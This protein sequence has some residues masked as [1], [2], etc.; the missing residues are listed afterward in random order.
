V[1]SALCAVLAGI[2]AALA[3][4]GWVVGR[5]SLARIVPGLAA[6]KCNEAIALLLA[7]ASALAYVRCAPGSWPRRG[8]ALAAGAVVLI[9]AATLAEYAFAT[10]LG[11][12]QLLVHG[13]A[14]PYPGRP[15]ANTALVLVALGG[16]LLCSDHRRAW[17]AG[18]LLAWLAATLALLAL[19]GYTTSAGSLLGSGAHDRLAAS[20]ASLLALLL[21]VDVLLSGLQRSELAAATSE[22]PRAFA[23]RRLLPAAVGVPLMLA[24]LAQAAQRIGLMSAGIQAWVL[25]SAVSVAAVVVA[26][27]VASASERIERERSEAEQTAGILAALVKSSPSAI[28]ALTRS[29]TIVDWNSSAEQLYG[30]TAVQAVGRSITILNP[31]E[32]DVYRQHVRAAVGGRTSR[33]ETQHVTREGRHVDVE[34]TLSPIRDSKGTV[35]GASC[36]AHDITER[37]RAER[38]LARLAEAAEYGTDAVLSIDLQGRVKHWNDGAAKLYGYSAGEAIE[39]DARDL[40][41]LTDVD[42]HIE[43]IR[44]GESGYQYEAHRRRDDGSVVDVLTSIVPWHANGELVG[45][46]AVTIDITER[47]RAEQAIAHLAAIVESSDNAIISKSLDGQITS[48]NAA[49]EQVYGYSA[50]QAVGR[51]VSML[52]PADRAEELEQLLASVA[53]GEHV[54]HLETVRRRKDGQMI[55][56]SLTVSPIRGAGGEIDGA[57]AITRDISVDKHFERAREQALADLEEAQR[58]ARVGSWSWDADTDEFSWSAQMYEIYARDPALGPPR[59]KEML[60]SY[61]APEDR[62]RIAAGFD[63]AAGGG[64]AFEYDFGLIG[65]DAVRRTVHVRGH[66]DPARPRCYVGTVQ[67]VT[68]Q[69]L[70]EAQ[71]RHSE[72]RQ[73]TILEAAPIGVALVGATAP[74]TLSYAN[75]ALAEMLG[76]ERD[77]LIGKGA[78]TIVDDSQH[79]AVRAALQRLLDGEDRHVSI[80]L[81]LR[82]PDTLWVTLTGAVI[83]GANGRPEHVVLQLQDI[84]ERRRFED[85]LRFYAERDPLTGLL[86]RRRLEEELDRAVAANDRYSTP[87]TLLVCDLDSLKLVNDTL[88]HKAGDELIKSVARVLSGGLRRS[89]VLGRMGGDEF[90]V[91]MPH[92]GL[93]R[94]RV[95]AER[96]RTAVFELDLIAGGHKLHTTLSIGIAPIGEGLSAEDSLV[97]ADLA[98][99]EAKRNGRNRI[100]T[101]RQ[102]FTDEAMSRHLGWLG[103][104]REALVEDRF[105]LHA[106]PITNLR[107]GVVSHLEVLL[108]LREPDGELLLPAAF[109]PTAE[110]FG[111]IAEIDRWVVRKAIETLARE[112]RGDIAYAINLSGISVGD[113][114]LLGLI[115]QQIAAH[116]VDPRRLIFEFTE[117]AAIRDLGASREFTHALARIGCASALDDFGSGFGS[118]SYL[119][120]LPVEYLKIDGD[121]VRNLPGSSDD[122]ILVKAIVDVARGLHKQTIAEFVSSNE[123]LE[124]LRT[125]GVDYAQ[126]FHIGTPKPLV[127]ATAG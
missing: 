31:P 123:A 53:A 102:A 92:T 36:A 24:A 39:H 46:T 90:A 55:D 110:R 18:S 4:L 68:E 81:E 85:E 80:D 120:H 78:L 50:H 117:T 83:A 112:A 15:A 118:F 97:A 121:F 74:F 5:Q 119:K 9:G 52:V 62:A 49:A 88:G 126:G 77:A 89:D 59:G 25:A 10:R 93:Q 3:L 37:K 103:R 43:R 7:S 106:Q 11:I 28:I 95:T 105:E 109:V 32:R 20:S 87:A 40:T 35:I 54:R 56:V 26:R 98:M 21:A 79:G 47:K 23:L 113:P 16:A 75:S 65:A 84:T 104:L 76:A 125:F 58:I 61:V 51:N 42:E 19:F 127:P 22:S 12:D 70:A 1:S 91:V 38:E 108:R 107:S 82:R 17:W 30:Y 111:V 101:S 122:R 57:S 114:E 116:S 86:N 100:A 13:P 124:L 96:L 115:E 60:A 14:G 2:L 29:G 33:L 63:R 69:R 99:Y 8:A 45:V 41:L 27:L 6:T 34:V 66:A 94:A 72:E 64:D 67:D 73:R 71:L 48:W 44:D